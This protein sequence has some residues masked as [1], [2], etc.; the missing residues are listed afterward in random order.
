MTPTQ[1]VKN[2]EV[3]KIIGKKRILKNIINKPRNDYP[4]LLNNQYFVVALWLLLLPVQKFCP[5]TL[6]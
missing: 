1:S 4:E 3:T 2:K 6:L 5:T